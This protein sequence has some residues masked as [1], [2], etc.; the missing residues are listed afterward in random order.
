MLYLLVVPLVVMNLERR[1]SWIGKVSPMSL[2]YAIGLVV[3]NATNAKSLCDGARAIDM[4]SNIAI[5]LAIPLMLMSCNLRSWHVGKAF[6]VFFTGLLAI[7]LAT[8][9][10]F[11]LF[12]GYY[13]QSDFAKISAVC[14]GIY[15]GGMPN[16]G[17]IAKGVEISNDL[18]LYVTS[19]DLVITG[20]YLL[21]VIFFAKN[22][23]RKLLPANADAE[24]KN[25]G[26]DANNIFSTPIF[27]FDRDHWRQSLIAVVLAVVIA[28]L[29]VAVAAIIGGDDGLNMTV[30]IL[31]LTT[32][33]IGVSFV[34]FI[35]V[36]EG[37]FDIGLYCTYVFCFALANGC[38]VRD[39]D[40]MG[41]LNILA[42]I[43]FVVF[44]S[45]VLQ[46]LFARLLHIDGDSVLVGSVALINSPPFVPMV[47]ALLGN[48]NVIVTGICI[49]LLGYVLGNYLGIGLF[50]LLSLF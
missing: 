10:G 34:P 48:R 46:V 40:L 29:S 49:G 7:L 25:M 12:R 1:W 38:D 17:A 20:L 15:T 2:L 37:S 47:A 22:V 39:M 8:V 50:L 35:H 31:L 42:Y 36:G 44:G 32:L 4:V 45:L 16:I 23:F 9:I 5:P 6:K 3:A 33:A 41:S 18:F 13:S 43:A 14:I 19:Y 11:F 24:K 28:G 26:A 30:L 21:F 27:P